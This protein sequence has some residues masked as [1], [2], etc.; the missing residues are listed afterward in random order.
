MRRMHNA[1]IDHPQAAAGDC[2]KGQLF[3][4]WNSELTYKKNIHWR[5]QDV[6]DFVRHGYT[7]AGQSQHEQ[8]RATLALRQL[9][10]EL[11]ARIGSVSKRQRHQ[12]LTVIGKRFFADGVPLL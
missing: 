4:P 2:S 8:I 11:P 1:L 10:R 5:M 3:V 7:A 12:I 9:A 6:C